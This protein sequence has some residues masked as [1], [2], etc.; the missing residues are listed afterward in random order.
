MASKLLLLLLLL[1]LFF[2]DMFKM[3]HML[4]SNSDSFWLKKK[5]FLKQ[6]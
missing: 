3:I 4:F 6:Y 5:F 1:L 2:F